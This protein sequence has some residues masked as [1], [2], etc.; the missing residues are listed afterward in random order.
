MW[1][2]GSGLIT[3][4]PLER[5]DLDCKAV[6]FAATI[7][8]LHLNFDPNPPGPLPR[9]F[10]LGSSVTN[11]GALNA[12]FA[13]TLS[14]DYT[15]IDTQQTCVMPTQGS[16]VHRVLPAFGGRYVIELTV[17]LLAHIPLRTTASETGVDEAGDYYAMMGHGVDAQRIIYR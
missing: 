4:S 5:G 10:L 17:S 9:L 15:H 12:V 3:G 2:Q 16:K 1:S 13:V 7:R 6:S 14:D 11:P 8:R